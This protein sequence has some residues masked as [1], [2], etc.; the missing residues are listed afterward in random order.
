MKPGGPPFVGWKGLITAIAIIAGCMFAPAYCQTSDVSLL[1][2]QTPAKAGA[3]T[4]LAGVY[5][6]E[7]NSE[8]TLTAVCSPLQDAAQKASLSSTPGLSA[9]ERFY[10]GFPLIRRIK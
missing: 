9:I 4:P 10:V 1:L 3:T 6:F 5:H 2:Q 8:V 7:L